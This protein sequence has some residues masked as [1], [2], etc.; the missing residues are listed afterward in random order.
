MGLVYLVTNDKTGQNYACKR[1]NRKLLIDNDSLI[2]FEEE[3]RIHQSVKHPHIVEIIEVK[4]SNDFIDIIME[5]CASGSLFDCIE[6]AQKLETSLINKI[7]IQILSAVEYIH[8]KNICHGD[9][10][11]E[12]ILIDARGNVKVCDFGC[13]QSVSLPSLNILRGTVHYLP[14]E[15]L[16]WESKDRRKMDIWAIGVIFHVLVAGMF[17]YSVDPKNKAVL[18]KE[19]KTSISLLPPC[20]T[21]VIKKALCIDE[22]QRA[23]AA[24]LLN[25]PPLHRPKVIVAG[26]P[27]MRGNSHRPTYAR[28]IAC[29][30]IRMVSTSRI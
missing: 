20:Y 12:N 23:T 22:T 11:P 1:I 30:I 14:P 15:V 9:L 16:T 24:E 5:Y 3:L 6:G 28:K 7:M 21:Q 26:T 29:P 27:L 13:A 25:C 17:P 2:A 8:K 19:I 10:K 18:A 4:Y